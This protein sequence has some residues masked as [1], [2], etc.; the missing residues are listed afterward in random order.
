MIIMNAK[1]SI[2]VPVYNSESYL[3]R[4]IKS[5][6][7]QTY[8]EF[9]LIL[10][11][12]GSTDASGAICDEYAQKDK[13]IRVVHKNNTGVSDTRNEGIRL[14][15]GKYIQ[16]VDSDDYLEPC[17]T[18]ELVE[19]IEKYQSDIV[20][21]GYKLI[22]NATGKSVCY[23]YED[24]VLNLSY[25]E[26][27]DRFSELHSRILLNPPWNKLY[28]AECI[29]NNNISFDS[30][31]DLAE[32]LIFTLEALRQCRNITVIP[33]TFYNYI[34]YAGKNNLTYKYRE[35]SYEMTRAVFRK[36]NALLENDSRHATQ[37]MDDTYVNTLM[38]VVL[39]D[40][41]AC[42]YKKYFSKA[43]IMRND[44]VIERRINR[45]KIESK[46]LYFVS[47]LFKNRLYGVIYLYAKI[48]DYFKMKFPDLFF[49]FKWK[50]L[51]R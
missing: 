1:V 6:L 22:L 30:T 28:K 4:C 23:S 42:D 49:Y 35:N 27:L 20:I 37:I 12:D 29:K 50:S 15:K 14:S 41:A 13:R 17:A 47:I 21:C 18:W 24:Q 31:I 9:E 5:I 34:L 25:N 40:A 10:V 8:N 45:A 39:A 51:G 33:S 2:I 19:A 7:N 38:S 11:D 44:K 26:Y 48:K 46:Q 43:C 32:D 16:F 36:V 3:D